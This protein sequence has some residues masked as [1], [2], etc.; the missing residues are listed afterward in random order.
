MH[1]EINQ[2]ASLP[3]N[4]EPCLMPTGADASCV[5]H[6]RLWPKH[7]LP[8]GV[9]ESPAEIGIFKVHE[10]ALVEWA[11]LLQCAA[12]DKEARAA[13]PIHRTTVAHSQVIGWVGQAEPLARKAL[14]KTEVQVRA[15]EVREAETGTRRSAVRVAEAGTDSAYARMV[16]EIANKSPQRMRLGFSI[17]VQEEY[18]P[19]LRHREPLVASP[20]EAHI[21]AVGN[22]GCPRNFSGDHPGASIVRRVVHD[23]R[24]P[25]EII[26]AGR[27]RSETPGEVLARVV[28]YYDDR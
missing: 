28:T 25:L 17:T 15:R 20:G 21:F 10:I 23:N 3:L 14:H 18:P 5:Q 26:N 24:L 1:G 7:D 22:N 2:P 13:Q 11:C 6:L 9:P 8:S 12:A 19:A 16:A 27:Q 4:A